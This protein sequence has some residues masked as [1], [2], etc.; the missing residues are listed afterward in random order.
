[1]RNSS[2]TKIKHLLTKPSFTAAEAKVLGVG[3]SLLSYYAG[4]GSIERLSHGVYQGREKDRKEVPFEWEDLISTVTSVPNGQVCL[5]SALAIYELTDEIPRQHWIAIPHEQFAP[6]RPLTKIIRMR[7]TKMGSS[8]LKLGKT[9]INIFN[10]E[11]TIIDAFRFLTPEI[12]IKALKLYLSG[13]NGKPDLVTLRKYSLKL[14]API[15]KYV[16][17]LT[18]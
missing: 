2:L 15:E 14:K 9:S 16:E 8:R 7:D 5:V 11:R 17:A 18:L 3:A 13:K 4:K 12:A 10:K 1:M 6:R